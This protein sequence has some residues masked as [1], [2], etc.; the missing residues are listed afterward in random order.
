MT[1][2]LKKLKIILKEIQQ[3]N[4]IHEIMLANCNFKI[5]F[6]HPI[7]VKWDDVLGQYKEQRPVVKLMEWFEK[8]P[9]VRVKWAEI[10]TITKGE[11]Q[12]IK[13]KLENIKLVQKFLKDDQTPENRTV[14]L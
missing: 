7:S 9:N 6:K 2:P 1:R 11:D 5:S 14:F 13:T 10:E 4:Y 8:Y 3:N 12:I